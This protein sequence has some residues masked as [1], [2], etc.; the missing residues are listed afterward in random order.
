MLLESGYY[1]TVIALTRRPI[2]R[3]HSRLIQSIVNFD[4]LQ[5]A[6][7]S[8]AS[9]IFC[10]LGTTIRRAGSQAAFLKVDFEYPR[11]L[12]ARGVAAGAKQFILVSSVGVDSRSGNF[13]L[14][15]KGELE[16]AVTALPFQSTH[17]FRPSFLIGERSEKRLGESIGIPI[18]KALRFALIGKLRKYRAV[19]AATVAA[20]MI[21]AAKQGLPGRHLYHYD[22][23]RALAGQL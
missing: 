9:D 20:A 21:A 11:I 10:A 17:I 16:K 6:E 19:P 12:A 15:V 7:L 23:I 8:P 13:Y 5:E 14:R 4:N 18:A 2:A 22:E 3:R 1:E